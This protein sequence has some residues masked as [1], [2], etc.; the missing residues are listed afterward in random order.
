MFATNRR[1]LVARRHPHLRPMRH[2]L[3]ATALLSGG[4]V[5][6]LAAEDPVFLSGAHLAVVPLFNG[7]ISADGRD[8]KWDEGLRVELHLRDYYFRQQSHHPFAEL[9]V[10]YESH[11]VKRDGFEVDSESIALRGAVGSAIPLW[12]S[13]DR[14]IAIGLSPELG[15]HVGSVSLDARSNGVH[16][17][18]NGFRYG[19]SAGVLGWASFNRAFS[20]GLGVVG[21]YWRATSMTLT[22]PAGGGNAERSDS[23]SGWDLGVRLSGGFVF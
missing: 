3:L 6:S 13:I 1:L 18:D 20:L 16:S 17:D 23:P 12:H 9:G 4:L 5:P 14:A 8:T 22:V 19:A 10:F 15:V 21:S 11:D 7:A 2:A